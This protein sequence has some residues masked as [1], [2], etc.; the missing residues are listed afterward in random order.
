[1]LLF[2]FAS[3]FSQVTIVNALLHITLRSAPLSSAANLCLECVRHYQVGRHVAPSGAP[4]SLFSCN[5]P[6]YADASQSRNSQ[7]P[8]FLTSSKQVLLATARHDHTWRRWFSRAKWQKNSLI[9]AQQM[10][11]R[12]VLDLDE[13]AFFALPTKVVRDF[14]EHSSQSHCTFSILFVFFLDAPANQLQTFSCFFVFFL[15]PPPGQLQIAL[16]DRLSRPQQFRAPREHW[17]RVNTHHLAFLLEIVRGERTKRKAL[18]QDFSIVLQT[19]TD[20]DECVHTWSTEHRRIVHSSFFPSCR[21]MPSF[22]P[23]SFINLAP[24]RVPKTLL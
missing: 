18:R 17:R 5:Q 3:D 16:R 22:S 19:A 11:S 8:C 24:A 12:S 23:S 2:R 1:M 9:S 4:K 15:D 13:E 21:L 20:E 10:H 14:L 6:F 7:F